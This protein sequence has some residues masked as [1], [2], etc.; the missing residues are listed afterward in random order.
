MLADEV[1]ARRT[2]Q[3]PKDQAHDDRV[4]ELTSKGNEVGNE[5][6][7]KRQVGEQCQQHQLA[8]P[9]D[10]LVSDQAA[11]QHETVGNEA[12]QRAGLRAPARDHEQGYTR[13]PKQNGCSEREE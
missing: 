2:E 4:V 1:N 9:R 6:E 13:S 7:G 10:A 8:A 5:V 12:G 11:K 3:R